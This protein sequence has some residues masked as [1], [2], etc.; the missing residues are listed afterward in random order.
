MMQTGLGKTCLAAFFMAALQVLQ[1]AAAG[2]FFTG[3]QEDPDEELT[4]PSVAPRSRG[5]LLYVPSAADSTAHS[6]NASPLKPAP[7]LVMLHGCLQ[8][9]FIS[10]SNK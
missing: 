7:L 3:S 6:A 4:P 1:P 2:T 10:A 8:K 5:Y 9:I